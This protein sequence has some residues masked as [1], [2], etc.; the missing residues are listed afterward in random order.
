MNQT[1]IIYIFGNS[2]LSDDSLPLQLLPDL[3]KSFPNIIFVHQD[4]NEDFPPP[5]E[6]NPHIIDTVAGISKPLLLDLSD[7]KLIEQTPVS[8]HD[9]DLLFH[10]LLLKKLKKI[11]GAKIF[12]IP[13]SFSMRNKDQIIVWFRGRITST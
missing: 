9:Y 4:P 11:D 2:L 3:Q 6:R 7:L 1:T 8:P 12:G 5:T 13:Q 10:L